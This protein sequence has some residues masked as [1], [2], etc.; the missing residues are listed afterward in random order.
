[1]KDVSDRATT[2][3]RAT[4]EALVTMRPDT[5]AAIR[6]GTVPKGDV[7][8]VTRAAGLLGLKRTPD[9][10]PFCHV[11][12]VDHA[13]VE[14]TVGDDGVRVRV[15]VTAVARTG[16]EVEAMTGAAVAALNVYD[17]VKPLDPTARLGGVQVVHKSGGR[18]DF[19]R[20]AAPDLRAG[21]LVV[22]DSVAAGRATDSAG[23][24]VAADLAAAGVTVAAR[25]VV[26]DDPG[27]IAA[28]VRTWTDD[29]GLGL[30]VC[31]GGTGPGPRDVT[32]EALRPLL[33]KEIPGLGEAARAHGGERTPLACLSRGLGGLRGEAVV[34]ALPGAERAARESLAALLP[35]LLHLP[36]TR[37]PDFRHGPTEDG[38]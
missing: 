28:A 33:D 9:L 17:M 10:L 8:A 26:A 3:R 32:P 4:A 7:A 16:V 27:A 23:A 5:V 21:V 18:S 6:A 29:A 12:P 19:R 37:E 31:V 22:S 24:A 20:G 15:S 35:A 11:I 38:A 13:E 1:M 34:V 14:V 25:A 2:L 30:V 36:R